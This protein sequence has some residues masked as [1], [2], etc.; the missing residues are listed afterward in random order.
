MGTGVRVVGAPG[1]TA[2]EPS[3]D[4]GE[5]PGEKPGEDLG[6]KPGEDL[7]HRDRRTVA[8]PVRSS[9]TR[10]RRAG[11][12]ALCAVAV[13]GLTGTAVFGL[14]W[15][16]LEARRQGEAQVRHAASSFLVDLTN[17]DPKTVDADFSAVTAMATG[18]FAD[19][20]DKFFNSSI[21]QDLEKALASSRGQVRSMYV[22]TYTGTKASVYAVV[23]QLY[24]NSKITAPQSDV[25]RIVLDL[26]S[27]PSGWKISNVTVLEGPSG[28]SGTSTQAGTS[29]QAGRP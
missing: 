20:A 27:A 1:D 23:D 24:A 19:Q 6:E 3:E 5:D 2:A 17:F 4:L 18:G 14:A 22:Q 29:S 13:A 16:G 21:R 7:D 15:S 8:E 11:F 9:R 10:H 26:S 28:T 12:V 25:L